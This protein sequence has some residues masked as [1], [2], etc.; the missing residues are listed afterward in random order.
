MD[1]VSGG[2]SKEFEPNMLVEQLLGCE[3]RALDKTECV[4]SYVSRDSR[5]E[6]TGMKMS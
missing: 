2:T 3:N 1:N 5:L 4:P 6:R